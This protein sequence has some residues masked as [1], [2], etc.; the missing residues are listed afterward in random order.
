MKLTL[1]S[2][3]SQYIHSSTVP[4]CLKA[5]VERYGDASI[6]VTIVEGNINEP[7]EAVIDR[8][9]AT[10]PDVLGI[11]CYIWNIRTVRT[12][13]PKLKNLP[14]TPTIVLGGP[15]V[16]YAAADYLDAHPQIDCILSGEG[17]ESLPGYLNALIRSTDVTAVPGVCV[18]GHIGEP[19]IGTG[20]PVKPNPM[21]YAAS[22]NG[23]IAYW[24][25]SRGCPYRCAFC[26]SGRCGSVRFYDAQESLQELVMLAQHGARTV[27][28]VD[29]T[30]NA[31][32][33]RAKEFWR[34][35]IAQSDAGAI[36]PGTCYHF[37]IAGDILDEESLTILAQAPKGLFQLEIGMQ[38]FHEPT[39]AAVHRKTDTQRLREN[40]RRL[41]KARNMHIH[42]DLIAGLPQEDLATF[43][44]SFRIAYDLGADMLQLGF[45]KLLHG[46][47]MREYPQEFP[48]T[49]SDEPP[50]EVV[51]TPWMSTQDL[52]VLR[53]VEHALDRLC[54]SG[55]FRRTMQYLTADA[56]LDIW[57]LLRDFGAWMHEKPCKSLEAYMECFRN[58]LAQIPAVDVRRAEDCMIADRIATN[59]SGFIPPFLLVDGDALHKAK[60]LLER[61]RPG[62]IKRGCAVLNGARTADAVTVVWADYTQPDPITQEYAL[63][64]ER[65]RL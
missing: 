31:N 58:Y 22:L 5:G 21:E 55:R 10:T 4:W 43:A 36:P 49:F 39:L 53:D 38:S 33:A 13:L 44:R 62:G 48:C 14:G 12:L 30:F 15:E 63:R 50:Y 42:I 46:A 59:S 24:E 65:V 11:S 60:K 26:L 54:N 19:V 20:T 28:L 34:F 6:K 57:E 64:F 3:H 18:R 35:L 41:V 7:E 61:T 23:R 51:Q 37:E 29:R 1:L 2:L 25:T 56:G 17:E 52:A 9:R 47:D 45:L 32:P 16:S 8:I 40:I 27:K